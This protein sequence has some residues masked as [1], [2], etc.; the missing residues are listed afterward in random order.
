MVGPHKLISV[1]NTE[2]GYGSIKVLNRLS[3]NV[4]EGE[5]L[6][7]LGHNGMGKSTLIRL[8]MG[9]LPAWSGSVH[10]R[11]KDITR[12]SI[13]ERALLGLGYV[14]QGRQIFPDLTVEENLL[15]GLQCNI[16]SKCKTDVDKI[17][18][19]FP[20]LS[21]LLDRNGG[22]LSG[23]EQQL[24]ALAR[25]LIGDPA[26]VLLDEPTE[27]IQPNILDEIVDTLLR[28]KKERSLSL[29]LVEQNLDFILDLSERVVTLESGRITGA[30]DPKRLQDPSVV[31]EYV[32]LC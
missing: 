1:Q 23:G 22:V 3:L 15:M 4:Q 14:P 10:F 16:K 13:H 17:L 30:M 32:G 19:Y 7:I 24:L 25:C 6:G 8:I 29:V 26:V 31:Q 28:F 27:G 9:Y 5:F 20:R 12:L 18:D 11:G 21:R 2:T